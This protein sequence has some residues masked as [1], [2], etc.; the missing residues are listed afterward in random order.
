MFPLQTDFL[1]ADA[2]SLRDAIENSLR[3][4]VCSPK[5]ETVAVD[6]RNY[7]ELNAIR[8]T[9]DGAELADR[10]P[11]RPVFPEG[12]AE[13]A[14]SVLD[15]EISGRP[16]LLRG[17]SIDLSCRARALEIGQARDEEGKIILLLRN[18]AEGKLEVGVALADLEALVL[19]GAKAAG[20]AH[21]VSV[22]D[23]R[24]EL[25]AQTERALELM[26][27]VRA[28]KLFLSATVR[29][30]GRAEIDEQLDA[31]LVGLE[32]TGDGTLG[33]LACGFIVPHLQRFDGRAFSLLAL[34]LGE[35]KLRDIRIAAGDDLRVTAEFGQT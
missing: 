5:G 20:A 31:R 35:M 10:P 22:E 2:D 25:R 12:A 27:Q 24:I 11:R 9:L 1:P 17:A 29:I 21:G 16:L 32:C 34:P 3:Q 8:I 13:P 14:F 7:P 23:V 28:K 30:T 26:V 15:F 4:V 33:T 19:A 18:A 6:D